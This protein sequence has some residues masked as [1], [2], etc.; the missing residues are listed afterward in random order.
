[1]TQHPGI[2][3][4]DRFA[5][6][7]S[8]FY[9][10]FFVYGG[11]SLPFLPVWLRAKGLDARQIGVMLAVPLIVRLVVVPV[12]TRLADRF[13]ILR[14]AL[15]ATATASIAGFALVG[16]SD[17]FL[18]ILAAMA[19]ASAVS[20]PVLPLADAYALRGLAERRRS[21]GP[22]RLWGSV[23]F[24][25]AN[26]AGGLVLDLAGAGNLIWAL[27]AAQALAALAA[28]WLRPLGPE[29]ALLAASG[30]PVR[31]LWR[32]PVF[33]GVVAAASLI[34]ASHAVMYGFATLQWTA[35]GLDGPA[36]GI[37]WALGVVA[38]I[39]LFAVS[40]RIVPAVGAI[41][42]IALGA[43]GAMIRWGAMAFDLPTAALPALQCLHALSFGAT[44]LG[45]MQVLARCVPRGQGAT[46]Q[47]DFAAVQGVTFAAAMG[48]SGA[49]VEAYGTSAYAA[50]ALMSAAGGVIAVIARRR[51]P[52][53]DPL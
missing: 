13:A 52:D 14:G 25:V 24:I 43:L 2:A 53:A 39:C 30:V 42:M 41:E 10:A 26:L 3:A 17:G 51:W 32:M 15:V 8:S 6:R 40:A 31:S 28:L 22:V 46:A 34:Q 16:V 37:L 45:T 21:Y 9:A 12:S 1:M 4:K 29:R 5:L 33:L 48:L 23:S 7:L 35:R 11:M 50:M 20:T 36:I 49:L 47:G 18:P 38:E 27:V 19:L 44:H